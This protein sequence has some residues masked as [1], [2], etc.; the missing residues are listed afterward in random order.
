VAVVAHFKKLLESYFLIPGLAGSF[1]CNSHSPRSGEELQAG[2]CIPIR[3]VNARCALIG[4]PAGAVIGHDGCQFIWAKNLSFRQELLETSAPQFRGL[5]DP[6]SPQGSRSAIGIS[7]PPGSLYPLHVGIG[8]SIG[9]EQHVFSR[10][11]T[12]QMAP[13]TRQL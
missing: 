6:V 2:R 12:A 10:S 11:W 3:T 9:V 1:I 4:C 13:S 7:C 8:Q 5:M